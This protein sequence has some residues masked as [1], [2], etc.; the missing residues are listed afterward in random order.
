MR[1]NFIFFAI[2]LPFFMILPRQN[3]W[4]YEQCH[5]SIRNFNMIYGT[6]NNVYFSWM[7]DLNLILIWFICSALKRNYMVLFISTFWSELKYPVIY[8][9]E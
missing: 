3:I 7:E 8:N 2:I 5:P 9:V 1:N 4:K 6:K